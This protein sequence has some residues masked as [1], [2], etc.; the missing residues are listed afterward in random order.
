MIS[1]HPGKFTSR[2]F[3]EYGQLIEDIRTQAMTRIADFFNTKFEAKCEL[4]DSKVP[5]SP[6]SDH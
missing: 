4:Y 5:P 6:N 1:A 2:D 3:Q